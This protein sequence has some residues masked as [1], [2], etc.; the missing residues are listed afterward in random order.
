MSGSSEVLSATEIFDLVEDVGTDLISVHDADGLY[1]YASPN[2]ERLFGWTEDD[3]V[4]RS[5][6]ELFH[7][8]D[9]AR[10]QRDH[11]SHASPERDQGLVRYRLRCADGRYRLVETRSRP[12]MD[13][14]VVRY[15][16][17]FTRDLQDRYELELD[18][19]R[20]RAGLTSLGLVAASA[21]HELRTPL[22]YLVNNLE[23][24]RDELVEVEA[25]AELASALEDALEGAARV[26]E[27]SRHLLRF[28]RPAED[29]DDTADLATA[30]QAAVRM[31]SSHVR[32]RARLSVRWE[33]GRTRVS[34][35]QWR[36]SQIVLNLLANAADAM[37]RA[38]PSEHEIIV[39][40]RDGAGDE[41]LVE[42]I[43]DGPGLDAEAQRRI[44]EP[45][46]S[47]KRRGHV[48]L[49]LWI[50]RTLSDSLDAPLELES[51]PGE[52][53]T[54]RLRLRAVEAPAKEAPVP[55]EPVRPARPL[56]LVVVDDEAM[57]GRALERTLRRLGEVTL[58]EDPTAALAYLEASAPVDALICDQVL[59]GR[60]DGRALIE[61]AER[62][63]PGL[64][65]RSV[66]MSG[67]DPDREL[68]AFLERTG[69]A[70]VGK[71][72]QGA[73]LWSLLAKLTT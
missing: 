50:C 6:Y 17:C 42:V 44:F 71:P 11:E 19:T 40:A 59:T 31:A 13:G 16:V 29:Q 26:R 7:P 67:E 5:A 51:A 23:F 65:A 4:G 56:H 10:I 43:D 20:A 24:V 64:M 52:G 46:F 60:L 68:R 62:R 30:V 12:K 1:L 27:L 9:I 48:G 21:A 14:D 57:I 39:R 55:S 61:E 41:V 28:A 35:G 69:C 45:L 70:F 73:Q 47:T 37:P 32:R 54:F 18:V 63:R 66:L 33:T 53:S 49:G 38:R 15:I 72:F 8:D 22:A 58:F 25:S 34:G 2:V 3:L 36:I